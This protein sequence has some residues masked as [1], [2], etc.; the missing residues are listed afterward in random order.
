MINKISYWIPILGLSF[1]LLDG[2]AGKLATTPKQEVKL[3][4]YHIL[5]IMIAILYVVYLAS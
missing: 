3:L 1:L 4:L 2:R 5:S